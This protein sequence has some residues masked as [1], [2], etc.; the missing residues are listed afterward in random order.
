MPEL[1]IGGQWT[2]ASDRQVREIRCPADGKLV[3]TV[4]EAGP[5]DAAA[6][7]G[8][9]RE[10]FDNGP[11]PGTPAAQRGRLLLRV[12]DLLER[13]KAAFA[14][15]ESLD[16][17]KRL[18]ESEYDMDDIANC[19]RYFGNLAA[20]G[21]TD[22]VID[23]GNPET[24][25]RVVHEP[26]GVCSLITPW[27][28][29]LLQT[30]WKVAPA[31]AAGNTFVLKPSELTPHTAILLM[32]L[33]KEAGLPD[34]VAN[35]VLGAGAVAGAPL[36]TDERVDLVSFTGGLVTGR[37]IMAAAA[38]TVKKIALELG[39]KNPNIVF[40]DA[41]FDTAVDFAL[42]AVFLHSGQ[43]CSAGARLLVQDELHDRFVDELVRRA[44]EIRLGGPFDKDARTGPLISAAH[45]DKV[46]AYVAAGLAEGAVLRCGGARP[47]DPE[48]ANG[49][50]YPPT[51][52]DECTPGMSVVRDESFGPVLTVERFRDEAE[53]V[54]LANDTVYGLAGAVW[55]QDGERAHR[56]AARLRVGTVWINDFHPY[57]PQAE[58]GGMKQSGVGREL[59]P[60]GLAE[61][62]EAKHIWRNTAAR[63]QRW[64][65]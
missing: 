52:L 56:V 4:D 62:Q 26:V 42:M 40:A 45:R 51:V 55:T 60:A 12:A 57:V 1:F 49:Y 14:R 7:V 18:V 13:D 16:T 36:S 2:A 9:A 43:V 47:E 38:P 6:A 23:T 50:Y 21:G 29:P 24:D 31:L 5:K 53:A 10:A 11:W 3:A 19:F 28:Y 30:A 8:A 63:P 64:F 33:L 32:G 35:L 48:L 27:N 58:W 59:G 39:G 25:S 15:A 65:E 37:H 61:Y 20:S 34:G 44:Q 41:E 46:E 17:G 22:R 54:A